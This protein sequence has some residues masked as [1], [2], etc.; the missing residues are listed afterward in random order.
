M[1]KKTVYAALFAVLV[2][3][4]AIPAASSVFAK[5]EYTVEETTKALAEL[6][7]YATI[8]E[9]MLVSLDTT[10][11][12]ED[13]I[14]QRSI[15]IA[16]DYAEAQN[17]MIQRIHDDPTK[18]MYLDEEYAEKFGALKEKIAESKQ[19]GDSTSVLAMLG[20]VQYASAELVCGGGF[21]QH[22]TEPTPTNSD[23]Y[24]TWNEALQALTS[25]GYHLVPQY[26]SY[27]YGIDYHDPRTLYSCTTDS[28]RYQSII[29]GS[30]P[31]VYHS[32]QHAPGEPN[33]EV[34]GAYTWPVWW[35]GAY[36]AEWHSTY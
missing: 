31:F 10:S 27:N 26:A 23:Y 6:T 8:D 1:I 36:V 12:E 2:L 30:A 20:L 25:N 28:F 33:P 17:D 21:E 18:H 32:Q 15:Q 29:L 22:H 13:G 35:W 16:S 5:D 9:N 14:G 34:L 7:P 24:D 4:L 3:S 19:N 11:A